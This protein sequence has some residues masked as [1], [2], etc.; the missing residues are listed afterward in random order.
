MGGQNTSSKRHTNV[1]LANHV[2]SK[3]GIVTPATTYS[4]TKT[5]IL[6]YFFGKATQSQA[7]NERRLE[8]NKKLRKD[9]DCVVN[10]GL[11]C[12][13]LFIMRTFIPAN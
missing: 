2:D 9:K 6:Q 4:F 10:N 5:D 8:N 3:G 1:P 7:E 11:N 13:C 12:K